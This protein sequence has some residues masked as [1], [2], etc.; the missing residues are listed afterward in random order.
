MA[1]TLEPWF[2]T[3]LVEGAGCFTYS[4]TGSR[5]TLYFAVKWIRADDSLL[6]ALQ[7]FFGGV[8]TI[9]RV[10]RRAPT[11]GAGLTKAASYYR[12]CRKQELRRIVAHFDAYPLRGAKAGSYRIWRLMVL[13]KL[14]FPRTSRERLD[15]FATKLS[16]ASPRH[17]VSSAGEDDRR[18]SRTRFR[19][20]EAFG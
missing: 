14:E 16:A 3:G 18:T 4:R 19:N 17:A 9:Y 8:G 7:E 10:R 15:T 11:P 5:L 2:V 12:V 20:G 6:H 1:W 13:L